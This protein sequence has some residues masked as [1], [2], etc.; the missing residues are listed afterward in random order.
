MGRHR[1]YPSNA[2]RQAAY[3]VR[4]AAQHAGVPPPVILGPCTLYCSP[5]QPLAS[6]LPRHAAVVTDPPYAAGYDVTKTRRRP[7]AW[8]RNFA[9]Y[10]QAFN[11]TPWLTFS[12]VILFGADHYRDRLPRGGS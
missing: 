8:D 5:W 10:D 7:S 3:R 11:P 2:S 9:G 1:T 4:Q 12:E 6:F